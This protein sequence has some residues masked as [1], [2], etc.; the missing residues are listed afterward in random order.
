[1]GS[2]PVPVIIYTVKMLL[3]CLMT[4]LKWNLKPQILVSTINGKISKSY[5]KTT[6]LKFKILLN[7]DFKLSDG[8]YSVWDIQDHFEWSFSTKFKRF[9]YICSK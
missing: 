4:I 5:I 6:N 8:S 3:T 9:K 7:G 2:S 1:M